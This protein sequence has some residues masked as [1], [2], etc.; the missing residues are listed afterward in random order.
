MSCAQHITVICPPYGVTLINH[1]A[2]SGYQTIA[3]LFRVAYSYLS[4]KESR[5]DYNSLRFAALINRCNIMIYGHVTFTVIVVAVV[6]CQAWSHCRRQ[7]DAKV[8][9]YPP[10][11]L[12]MLRA[13]HMHFFGRNILSD[14]ASRSLLDVHMLSFS[15]NVTQ[16]VALVLYLS[17][18]ISSLFLFFVGWL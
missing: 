8:L 11:A 3:S 6:E 15:H 18:M 16:N 12:L 14:L 4:H 2:Q 5:R 7:F 9:N 13:R 10:V 1:T 17:F